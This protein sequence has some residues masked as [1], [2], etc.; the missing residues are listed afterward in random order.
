MFGR[1]RS[2]PQPAAVPSDSVEA[3]AFQ[4]TTP[5][6]NALKEAVA[7][8]SPLARVKHAAESTAP[9]QVASTVVAGSA[10]VEG[11]DVGLPALTTPVLSGHSAEMDLLRREVLERIDPVVAVQLERD[12][13]RQRILSGIDEM[14]QQ[15]RIPLSRDEQHR[16]VNDLLDDMLGIGPIQQLLEDLEITDIMVNRFDQIF[17][18]RKGL[19]EQVRLRFRDEQHLLNVARRIVGRIG[20]RVDETS[21]MVDARLADGSRVNVVIP[22]LSLDGTCMSIRKFSRDQISL[23]QLAEKGAMSETMA[24]LLGLV[25]SLRL[26]ILISGGTGAGKT[27][28][29]NALSQHISPR[30]RIVTIEDAAELKL[31]QPHVV[32]LETRPASMEGTVAVSQRELLRNALRMRPDRIILGEVRGGE[33]LEML[34]AMNTGHDGSMSTLH[35]NSPRDALIRLEN[36]LMMADTRLPSLALRQQIAGSV[37]LVVQVSRMRDGV[38][39]I[40]SISEVVGMEQDVILLQELFSFQLEEE[41]QGRLLGQYRSNGVQPQFMERARYFGRE[42]ELQQLIHQML[43]HGGRV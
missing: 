25:A 21:P 39:R 5:Q 13:L 3:S 16:L 41:Q 43:P 32:R 36:M 19:L 9:S 4:A 15:H 18:E 23:L 42:A 30:E 6:D 22:P 12:E 29:L 7:S 2:V 35:A 10:M 14:A 11:T 24:R 40:S 1:K 17:V 27:T 26:N 20:R 34:Q 33:A 38:R 31:Q 28:L 8:P 37:Q